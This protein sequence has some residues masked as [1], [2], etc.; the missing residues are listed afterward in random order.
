MRE[1]VTIRIDPLESASFGSFYPLGV[2][3]IPGWSRGF[4][5]AAWAERCAPS[6][7]P[8]AKSGLASSKVVERWPPLVRAD[9][10]G[11][12]ASR[13]QAKCCSRCGAGRLAV[14]EYFQAWDTD[15]HRGARRCFMKC[16]R[17]GGYCSTGLTPEDLTDDLSADKIFELILDREG[18]GPLVDCKQHKWLRRLVEEWLFN[19]A[20][21]GVRSGLPR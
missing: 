6:L 3:R 12:I 10:A 2:L 11:G 19:P 8:A 17:R 18:E 14:V 5:L 16:A 1:I 20:G 7:V 13:T 9:P 21:R 4:A 15:L